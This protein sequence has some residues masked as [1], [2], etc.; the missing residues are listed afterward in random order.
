MR[1]PGNRVGFARTRALARAFRAGGVDQRVGHLPLVQ[2]RENQGFL[3]FAVAIGILFHAFLQVQE[4][5]QHLQPGIGLEQALLQ[6]DGGVRA[7]VRRR[8]VAGAAR[9]KEDKDIPA[10][11]L[12]AQA[13]R[14]FL[15]GLFVENAPDSSY[16]TLMQVI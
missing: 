6:V 7:V 14:N 15:E 13:E 1:R 8:R 5:A 12:I 2:A 9:R 16:F 11:E 4:A 10:R 3:G